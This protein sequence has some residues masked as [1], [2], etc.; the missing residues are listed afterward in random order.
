MK[1][2]TCD[3][4]ERFVSWL[5]YFNGRSLELGMSANQKVETANRPRDAR[6]ASVLS[7]D[8]YTDQALWQLS[9]ILAGTKILRSLQYL[10]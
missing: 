2:K 6:V 3:S 10:T 1:R 9:V 4:R 5:F 8:S 7:G